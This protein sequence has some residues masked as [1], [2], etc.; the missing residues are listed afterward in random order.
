MFIIA[1]HTKHDKAY[2]TA[3][4]KKYVFSKNTTVKMILIYLHAM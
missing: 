3:F 1:K 2:S 4:G